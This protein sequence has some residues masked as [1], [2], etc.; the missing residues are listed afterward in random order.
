M[1]PAVLLILWGFLTIHAS[2]DDPLRKHRWQDRVLLVFSP[3]TADPL[4]QEQMK[5]FA[6]QEAG[7]DERNLVTY[8]VYPSSGK[9]P[10]M[11]QLSPKDANALRN[12]YA[13]PPEAFVVILI[14]KDGGEKERKVNELFS[15]PS[16]FSLIDAMPMRRQEMKRKKN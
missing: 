3:S 13:I 11:T 15:I 1:N 9:Y 16:L 10:N 7:L 6:K 4:Y 8:E 5:L 2:Q 12:T 14:G